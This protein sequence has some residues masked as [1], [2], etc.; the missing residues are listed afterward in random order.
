MAVDFGIDLGTATTVICN[1]EGEVLLN[2]PTLVI[3]SIT[4]DQ[5][6][7]IGE[8]A[9][10]MLGRTPEGVVEVA[11]IRGGAVTGYNATVSLLKTFMK[12]VN[13]GGF[14]GARAVI[15]VPCGISDVERRAVNEAAHN[16][17]IK[18]VA[19]IEAPLAAAAGCGVDVGAPHGSM[20]VNI[21]A[22]ICEAAVV[23]LG[24]IVVSHSIR[25]AGTSFDSAII[26]YVK[27]QHNVAIGEST[28]EG[29]KI[30]IGSVYS[31]IDNERVEVSGRDMV[32]GLP[33][34]A[35][36]TTDEIRGCIAETA[37]AIVDA[38]RVTLEQTP[39]ELAADIIESGIVLTGGGAMLRGL[40]RLIN[41]N[42]EI[43]V[44]IAENPIECVAVGA[45]KA[46]DYM[47]NSRVR[48]IFGR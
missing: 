43:P 7:A 32:T 6:V 45:A 42:T 16:A 29:I 19:L 2:E 5:V 44:Y 10:E 48:G 34:T 28:A 31:G 25:T 20:V 40:G 39:P 18:S 24:G 22:G 38:V 27:K 41:I 33:K 3:K 15:A 12:R 17:G 8:E 23:S 4:N 14:A 37:E 36:V 1:T 35:K 30:S 21:G 13:K 26:Q 9:S 47:L 11:P 46:A